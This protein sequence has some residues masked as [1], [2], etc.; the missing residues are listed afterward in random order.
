MP[1]GASAV[2]G[3][4]GLGALVLS[5]NFSARQIALRHQG[6]YVWLLYAPTIIGALAIVWSGGVFLARGS[7][8][9]IVILAFGLFYAALNIRLFRRLAARVDAAAP[10]ESITD[11]LSEEVA[12]QVL[13][14][15]VV[16]LLAAIVLLGGW[17]IWLLIQ[18]IR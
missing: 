4:L 8:G 14:R 9:G 11:A 10:G 5:R 12:D 7:V 3:V 18:R 17:A 15:T 16:G 13:I 1:D 6:R 2:V